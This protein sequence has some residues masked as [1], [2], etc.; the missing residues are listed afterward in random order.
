MF[1]CPSHIRRAKIRRQTYSRVSLSTAEPSARGF[2]IEAQRCPVDILPLDKVRLSDVVLQRA[3]R[4]VGVFSFQGWFEVR[5]LPTYN[6]TVK[7][8]QMSK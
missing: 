1:I 7:Y 2:R 3:D 6:G 4:T 8:K 5:L